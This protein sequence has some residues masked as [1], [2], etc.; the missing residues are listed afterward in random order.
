MVPSVVE[1]SAVPAHVLELHAMPL[2]HRLNS[3]SLGRST[4][5]HTFAAAGA[6]FASNADKIH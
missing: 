1:Q 3:V 5:T 2:R 6:R 4:P